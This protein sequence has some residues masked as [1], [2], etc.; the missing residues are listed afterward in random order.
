MDLRLD[1]EALSI[2]FP[3]QGSSATLW[4]RRIWSKTS[5]TGALQ[6]KED[7]NFKS[8]KMEKDGS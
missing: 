5:W 4:V 1:A 3:S 6:E 7:E 8:N 2:T